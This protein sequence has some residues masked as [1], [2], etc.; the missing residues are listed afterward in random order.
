MMRAM[1]LAAAVAI[2]VGGSIVNAD[3]RWK[4]SETVDDINNTKVRMLA[5]PSDDGQSLLALRV[6][7][8][9]VP[10]LHLSVSQM[11][12]PDATD[13]DE[14]FMGI[15]ITMRSTALEKPLTLKWR[16]PW[17]E[18]KV[19]VVGCTPSFVSEKAFAGD[20]VT[21]QLDKIGKR[22]KFITRGEGYEGLPDAVAKA[23]EIAGEP[24]AKGAE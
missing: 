24:P 3:Q 2:C 21:F 12:L 18:Y 22:Y 17:G 23:L 6:E 1:A 7:K 9:Q 4:Y 13:I 5:V 11:M 15:A 14:K 16:M 8:S 10:R 20:S 19:A